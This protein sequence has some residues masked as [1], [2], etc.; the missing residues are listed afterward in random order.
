MR[1]SSTSN[2]IA[3]AITPSLNAS[4]RALSRMSYLCSVRSR[5]T[6]HRIPSESTSTLR[7]SADALRRS[8]VAVLHAA[9]VDDEALRDDGRVD[10]PELQRVHTG[11]VDQVRRHRAVDVVGRVA[12]PLAVHRGVAGA[13]LRHDV[14]DLRRLAVDG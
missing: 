3:M 9:R 4:S 8:E 13:G 7:L 10:H 5:S 11:L 1:R 2:V 14:D 12:L 6:R